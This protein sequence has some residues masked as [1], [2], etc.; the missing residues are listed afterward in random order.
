MVE[1]QRGRLRWKRE[2]DLRT[3][4]WTWREQQFR[5]SALNR[6][7][8]HVDA[9]SWPTCRRR[10]PGP[11]KVLEQESAQSKFITL[12]VIRTRVPPGNR[13]HHVSPR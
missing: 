11:R 12:R 5:R 3:N 10:L 7:K 9:R 6:A 4:L 1:A 2:L 13:A 8:M